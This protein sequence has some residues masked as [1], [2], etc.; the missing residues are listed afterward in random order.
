MSS[1][2]KTT[3]DIK[4]KMG[5]MD[6]PT[7]IPQHNNTSNQQKVNTVKQKKVKVTVYLTEESARKLNEMCSK[8]L[9]KGGKMEKSVFVEQAIDLLYAESNE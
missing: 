7:D 1:L 8:N 9:L 3:S 6:Y 5:L 4:R 2:E